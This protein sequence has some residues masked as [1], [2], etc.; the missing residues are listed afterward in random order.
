MRAPIDIAANYLD[1]WN[2]DQD[3]DRRRLLENWSADASYRDPLMQAD[4]R[5]GV[6]SMIAGARAQFPGHVFALHGTPDGHGHCARF[7]WTLRPDG[8]SPV[9][10]GTDIVR[11]DAEGR[12][13]EVL[14]FLDPV[15]A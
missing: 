15:A 11:L 5:D 10:A 2:A 4:G 1:L 3:A 8:G 6:A 7:S 9:A 13:V 14:D 12:I